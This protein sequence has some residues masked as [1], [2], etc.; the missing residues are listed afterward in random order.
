MQQLKISALAI[1]ILMVFMPF[2]TQAQQYDAPYYQSEKVNKSKWAAEDKEIKQKLAAQRKSSARSQTSFM[3]LPMTW[4]GA[5]WA[6]RAAASIAARRRRSLT[7]W[8]WRVC[9]FGQATRSRLAHLP[10][11]RSTPGATPCARACC[12][13]L[14]PGQTDGLSPDEVT[15]AEVLS[16]AGYNTAMWG[17]WH[18]GE[19]PK[20]APENQGYDYA[21]YGLWNG[22]ADGW[23]GSFELTH[24]TPN[25]AK[26]PW[27]DFPGE[28]EYLDRTGIDLSVAGYVGR[29]GEGRKPIEG[30]AGKLGPDRQ[31]AFEEASIA[32][33]INYVKNKAQDEDPF[34]I[35]WAT[36]RCP[37][38]RIEGPPKGSACRQGQCPGIVH[39]HAQRAYAATAGHA[40]GRGHRRK[41]TSGVD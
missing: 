12:S 15:V 35:Y 30:V 33:I 32:Q 3:S 6:G 40:R 2:Q 9:A 21:Y 14:W 1:S 19:E 31:E 28:K 5:S 13:V 26:A 7:G 10:G 27:Y 23:P 16:E 39:V 34:F 17:K 41:H 22:A 24:E 37:G 25:I 20:H 38:E 36:S 8:R 4:V 18:L 29:K 11:S